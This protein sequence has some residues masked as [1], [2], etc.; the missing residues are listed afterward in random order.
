MNKFSGGIVLWLFTSLAYAD[1]L[2][3]C[4]SKSESTPDVSECLEQNEKLTFT[5]LLTAKAEL[6]NLLSKWE[7]MDE[8][9]VGSLKALN[10]QQDFFLKYRNSICEAEYYFQVGGTGSYNTELNCKIQM[11]IEQAKYLQEK[12]NYIKNY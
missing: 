5:N 2:E 9:R 3:E 4:Q 7:V 11:N 12:I 1:A 10:E 6:S 8:Y